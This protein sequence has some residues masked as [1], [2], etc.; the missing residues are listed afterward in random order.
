MTDEHF[1]DALIAELNSIK[2]DLFFT[3]ILQ[4][5]NGVPILIVTGRIDGKWTEERRKKV[6]QLFRDG[7]IAMFGAM[8]NNLHSIAKKFLDEQILEEKNHFLGY[9][10]SLPPEK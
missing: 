8:Y 3:E 1:E 4:A 5:V 6:I 10:I 2:R 7:K 9:P